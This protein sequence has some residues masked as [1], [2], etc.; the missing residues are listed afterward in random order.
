M[1]NAMVRFGTIGGIVLAFALTEALGTA[2]PP[3]RGA[4]SRPATSA[5][6]WERLWAALASADWSES[7]RA[8]AALAERGDEAAAFLGGR[9]APPPADAAS[10]MG[11][12]RQL[13]ASRYAVRRKAFERLLATGP[14][15]VAPL[16]DAL[17]REGLSAEARDRIEQV[18]RHWTASPADSV[19]GRRLDGARHALARI[20]TPRSRR[21]LARLAPKGWV[22]WGRPVEGVQVRL[23][24][25]KAAWAV[26]AEPLLLADVRNR[27]KHN[28]HMSIDQ[29]DEWEVG[30]DGGWYKTDYNT[31]SLPIPLP[32][33]G[34]Q[35]GIRIALEPEWCRRLGEGRLGASLFLKPGKHRIRVAVRAGFGGD[36]YVPPVRAVSNVMEITISPAAPARPATRPSTPK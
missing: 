27:G 34:E 4:A 18:I 17:K 24:A 8:I 3:P 26:G 36:A 32:P 10:V 35:D 22:P 5:K 12:L 16:R 19:E 2:P 13:D 11:L 21:L 29:S 25:A 33:G 14:S 23:R 30:C 1:E 20:D 28:L 31:T 15:A 6:V 7:E 9:L